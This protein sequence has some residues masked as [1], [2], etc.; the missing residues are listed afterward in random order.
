MAKAQNE[1]RLLAVDDVSLFTFRMQVKYPGKSLCAGEPLNQFSPF[2]ACVLVEDGQGIIFDFK[3]GG[4]WKDSELEQHRDDEQQASLAITQ[5][6]LELLQNESDNA[7]EHGFVS[8]GV[9]GF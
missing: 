7:V 9:C 8:R 4:E 5:E 2:A 3:S 6:C 1:Q